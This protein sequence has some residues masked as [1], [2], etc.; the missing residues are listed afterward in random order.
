DPA[1]FV[2][3]V[4]MDPT[5]P[6]TLYL[7]TYR[8]YKTTN[9]GNLWYIPTP[10]LPPSN[11]ISAIAVAPSHGSYVYVVT[12]SGQLF[13]SADGGNTF[14]EY[15]SALFSGRSITKIA[16]D[17]LNP[18]RAFV[19]A[20]GFGAGHLFTTSS[21]G[22]SWSDISSS[23]PD[24]PANAVALDPYG[25]IYVG[26]DVGVFVSTDSGASWTALGSG[27]PRAS[28]VDLVFSA[29][30]ALVVATHG[31]GV[32]QLLL[33]DFAMTANPNT[34]TVDAGSPA[35][36]TITLTPL[37]GF[38]GTVNLTVTVS[39]NELTCSLTQSTITLSAP[40]N[41]TLSCKASGGEY[42]MTITA[43]SGSLV[44]SILVSLT[45]RNL[46]G[47]VV[48]NWEGY[49]WDGGGEE[50]LTLNGRFLASLLSADTPANV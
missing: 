37:N 1:E 34:V 30:G 42:N 13:V 45:V 35:N 32:W 47:T 5:T 17:R 31:R 2:T 40:K 24:L 8:L 11:V 27:L 19:A 22:K 28:V 26:T 4:A 43:A 12:S 6:T 48:L 15:D 7:G 36:Y 9:S 29:T 14:T 16:V 46:G 25:V 10:G 50:N 3:A 39:T 49:D 23:L 18:L 44:H 33:P 38:S 41:S 21:G 20:S